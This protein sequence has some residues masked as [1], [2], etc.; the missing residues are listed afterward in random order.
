MIIDN[1]RF[2]KD[3]KQNISLASNF[4]NII[5][6]PMWDVKINQVCPPYLHILLGIVKKHHYLLENELH[7]I[8]LQIAEDISLTKA[9]LDQMLF[10]QYIG[11]LRRREYCL[12]H[13]ASLGQKEM[14]TRVICLRK[15]LQNSKLV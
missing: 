13:Y 11:E 6:Q 8:D 2:V 3:G 4:N 5:H 10:H 1:E 12:I 9:K 14:K 7:K 15:K